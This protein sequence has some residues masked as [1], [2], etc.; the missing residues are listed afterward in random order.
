MKALEIFGWVM[1]L[2]VLIL[3]LLF[4]HSLRQ[5]RE[6]KKIHRVMA[7]GIFLL[8]VFMALLF[9]DFPYKAVF[10]SVVEAVVL[11]VGLLFFLPAGKAENNLIPVAM[12]K[13]DER[14][15]MFARVL[16]KKG[17]PNFEDYYARHP[18]KLE[19]D[20]RIRS[21]P[22][23]CSPNAAVFDPI[24]ARMIN[25]GFHFL[26]HIR[27]LAEGESFAERLIADPVSLTAKIKGFAKYHGAKIV[28]I[29]ETK[30]YHYYSHRGRHPENY[31][32]EVGHPHKYAIVFAVEMD[33]WMVK[34]APLSQVSIESTKEYIEGAKIGMILAYF[35]RE[36][37]YESRN[38]MDGNYLVCA[39]LVAH[40]AGIGEIGRMGIII[41]EDYGPRVR[42]GVV[43]TNLPLV[44]DSP[45][46]FGVQDACSACKKCA[47][48]CPSQAI[49]HE[50]KA[51]FE[52]VSKW[53]VSQEKCFEFW[54][55]VGTDC[56]ICMNTCPYSKPDTLIHRLFR[57]CL[58]R[59]HFT[60][61]I[62]VS[63]DDYL[64][65]RKP[66]ASQKPDWM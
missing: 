2:G 6:L 63:L 5:E 29:T 60:R 27:P 34:G 39:P 31:G 20:D 47:Q 59:S 9:Y 56:A 53:K 45:I 18:E 12:P 15:I 58:K 4:V 21:L 65:G 66:V 51:Q 46:S 44:P 23:L 33:Y 26:E 8:V 3:L 13:I 54:C 55:K 19:Q 48:N 17:S 41:T 28:G 30:P 7:P 57:L 36:L 64:Y 50:G 10:L 35:I 40:D 32:E 43:T 42:L 24:S 22:G 62:M 25:S 61:Q 38:H 1:E 49:P 14:N 37:G 11:I 16:Y 52:G